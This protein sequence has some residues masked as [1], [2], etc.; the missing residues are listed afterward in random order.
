MEES[1]AEVVPTA[2]ERFGE[3]CVR[4]TPA[5]RRTALRVLHHAHD[6]EDTVQD[7]CLAAWKSLPNLR[8]PNAL[9]GWMLRIARNRAVTQARLRRRRGSP[10]DRV[11]DDALDRAGHLPRV[12]QR[13]GSS[14]VP[15][16]DVACFRDALRAM[17]APVLDA[18]HL[19]YLRGLT[20]REIARRQGTSVGGVKTR[21]YRGRERLRR[22]VAASGEES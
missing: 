5:M 8:E 3:V 7:A 14:E 20:L 19:R 2:R 21:L 13:R 15:P 17:P 1:R 10:E 11:H 9:E 12:L 4:M 16:D 22:A 6:A 18:L